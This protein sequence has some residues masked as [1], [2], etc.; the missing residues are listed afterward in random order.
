LSSPSGMDAVTSGAATTKKPGA[1]PRP[2]STHFWRIGSPT[3]VTFR[4]QAILFSAILFLTAIF[5]I[6][7]FFVAS[8]GDEGEK[9]IFSSSMPSGNE[10]AL[11]LGFIGGE[12][13][14]LA[15]ERLI[16]CAPRI[17]QGGSDRRKQFCGHRNTSEWDRVTIGKPLHFCPEPPAL[18][19]VEIASAS[20]VI[21]PENGLRH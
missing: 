12:I 8:A 9:S 2:G 17:I 1:V 4:S 7:N 19:R 6:I 5:L 16:E 3:I 11:V 21:R 20:G 13:V 18:R 15:V 10:P 14:K